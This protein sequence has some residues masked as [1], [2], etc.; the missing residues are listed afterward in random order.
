M[1][2]QIE[3]FTNRTNKNDGDDLTE[4]DKECRSIYTRDGIYLP[5]VD[6]W[7]FPRKYGLDLINSS[8]CYEEGIY[9][10]LTNQFKEIN[11]R[12]IEAGVSHP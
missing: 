11:R 10:P 9:T 8:Y 1:Y 2:E 3:Y 7:T 6:G 5:K 4:S 12:M